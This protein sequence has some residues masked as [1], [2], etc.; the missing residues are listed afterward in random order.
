M[1]REFP[2]RQWKTQTFYDLVR[3]ID[4]TGSTDRLTGRGAGLHPAEQLATKRHRRDR[5]QSG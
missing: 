3:K 1:I 4:Q 2:A 5:P